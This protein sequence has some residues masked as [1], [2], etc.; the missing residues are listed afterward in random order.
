MSIRPAVSALTIRAPAK[1]NLSLDVLARRPDGYHE[2]AGVMQALALHDRLTISYDPARSGPPLTCGGVSLPGADA[3]GAG[4]PLDESNL[5]LRALRA[6]EVLV[7]HPLPVRLHLEKAIP[8][9]AGL[10][11]GSSDAAAVLWGVPRLL[12]LE[13]APADLVAAAARLGADVPFFLLGGTCLAEGIGERLTPLP[14]PGR[15]PVVLAR[16]PLAVSTAEVYRALDLDRLGRRPDNPALVAALAAADFAGAC[17]AMA[18]VLESVTLARHPEVAALK[19]R[20]LALGAPACLMAGSGPT[21]F[22]LA[23]SQDEARC[24]AAGVADLAATV[25]VT[26][27]SPDGVGLEVGG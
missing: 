17:R 16:P 11:G 26:E 4:L 27:F 10:G 6:L 5:A 25:L 12:G 14:F 23:A 22:A 15:W 18:N 19:E 3:P 20:L 1:I 13:P 21:V 9:A 2:L 8:V 24:L 7:G